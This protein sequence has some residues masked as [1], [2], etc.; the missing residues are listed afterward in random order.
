MNLV[1]QFRFP[2][3]EYKGWLWVPIAADLFSE[4]VD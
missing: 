2:D 4:S 1:Q 3:A